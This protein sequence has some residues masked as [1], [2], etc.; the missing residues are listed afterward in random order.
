MADKINFVLLEM[1]YLRYFIPLIEEA[2]K[3][4]I[5]SKIF[6]KSCGKYSCPFRHKEELLN[7]ARHYDFGLAQVPELKETTG[8][9]FG[10]EGGTVLRVPEY[11]NKDLKVI[12][13]SYMTDFVTEYEKYIHNPLLSAAV[14]PSKYLAEHYSKMSSKNLYLG[15]PKYD[16]KLDK[17][18][19][20]SKYNL[21]GNKKVLF[22]APRLRDIHNIDMPAIFKVFK[23]E[24]F[25]VIVKSRGKDPMPQNCRGDYY[26]IDSSWHPHTSMELIEASDIIV[27]FSSSVIKECVL[28]KK[29]VINF[30]I[31]PF[32]MPLSGLYNYEYCQTFGSE[33]DQDKIKNAINRLTNQDLGD[34]F[35]MS[36]EK[37]LFTGNSSKRILDHLELY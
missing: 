6:V 17:Q 32:K 14:I 28:L 2:K 4:G 15:S 25:D 22:F 10:I 26:F 5:R 16:V 29:P 33:I 23:N 18:K 31:K 35:N 13:F 34:I 8:F 11:I 3:R 36:I 7:L 20:T 19:I 24:K 1:T 27:N 37:H 30:H 21:S 9:V 12:T